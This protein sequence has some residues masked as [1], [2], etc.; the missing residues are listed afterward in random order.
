M[1]PTQARLTKM[2]EGVLR[3]FEQSALA[4]NVLDLREMV[5]LG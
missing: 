4:T 2:L 5:A 1:R 3:I